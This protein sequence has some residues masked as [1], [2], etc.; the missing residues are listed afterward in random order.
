MTFPILAMLT[1]YT[2]MYECVRVRVRVRVCVGQRLTLS[3][4]PQEL[5]LLFLI[6]SLS[7][8]PRACQF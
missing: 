1:V 8:G 2:Y 5:S 7:L 3:A 6:D 4:V